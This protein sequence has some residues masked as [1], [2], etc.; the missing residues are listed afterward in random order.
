MTRLILRLQTLTI[1]TT[2]LLACVW[3]N[4]TSAFGQATSTGTIVGVVT[5]PTGAVVPEA[6][7]T[8][9]RHDHRHQTYDRYQQGRSVCAR[10]RATGHL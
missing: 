2:V 10:E 7:V 4:T 6:L 1:L 8:A 5:D 9:D 3:V